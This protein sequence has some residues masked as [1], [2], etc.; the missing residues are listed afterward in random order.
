[1]PHKRQ[2]VFDPFV[3]VHFVQFSLVQ[4]GKP[5][6]AVDDRENA[7]GGGFIDDIQIQYLLEVLGKILTLRISIG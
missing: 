3:N 5:A 6:Q 7:L 2:S 1:V 4:A